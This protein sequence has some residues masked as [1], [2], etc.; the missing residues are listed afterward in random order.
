MNDQPAA[1]PS[2]DE[3]SQPDASQPDASQ[4]DASQPDASRPD[5]SQPDASQPA[6]S[7]GGSAQGAPAPGWQPPRPPMP[8][9]G[10]GPPPGYAPS[11]GLGMPP[12]YAMPGQ[13]APA[14]AASA[15]QPGAF[16]RGF[17]L[18]A[19]AG[20]GVSVSLLVLGLVASVLSGLIALAF[21]GALAG[22]GQ[23]AVEPL[24]T[25][26]GEPTATRKVRAIAVS[27]PILTTPSDGATLGTGTY[28]YEVAQVLDGLEA[29]DADALV[30]LMNTPGG[31]V[32]GSRAMAEAVER[33]Q[34][35]TGRKVVAFVEGMSV[36]GGMYTMAGADEII[37]DHGTMIGHIGVISGP[38]LEYRGVT[39]V[40]STILEAG[41]TTSGGISADYITAGRNKD[42][43]NPW[44]PMTDEERQ[45]LQNLSDGEYASFVSWVAEGRGIPEGTIRE[46]M[47]ASIY[48][49][50]GAIAVGLIDAKMGRDQAF[51]RV[52]EI[53][54]LDPADT[55][56][57]AAQ[58]PTLW[59]QLLGA[60][61]R[62]YGQALPVAPVDGQPARPTSSMCADGAMLAWYGS[63]S[64]V[65]S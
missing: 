59:A 23:T 46:Q 48:G 51:R 58:P 5:A 1:G 60:E 19:G 12:A 11:P 7:Q 21:A 24:R 6:A 45:L 34:E 31:T 43:G 56:V 27:G 3:A 54:G 37:A 39:A 33:Y 52:A 30:L 22:A 40:G 15:P 14:P 57:V 20:L 36:S 42:I 17:S 63:L 26:W 13:S 50:D 10:Y 32:T 62:V 55:R 44:R 16:K 2:R 64:G 18:G 65:C 61:A 41:V 38:F 53:A 47:G 8:T 9:H 4:P 29:E 49:A 28:G 35:R 25:V